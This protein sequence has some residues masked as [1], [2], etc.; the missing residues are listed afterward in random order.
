MNVFWW[1]YY[2]LVWATKERSPLITPDREPLLYAYIKGKADTIGCMVEAIGVVNDHIHLIAS[3][4][5][6]MSIADFVKQIKGSSAH[7]LNHRPNHQGETFAWQRG[8]G[9]LT[10]GS[11]QLPTAIEYVMNQ[12]QHHQE[13]HT[14]DALE[15]IQTTDTKPA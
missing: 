4:P 9:V 14:I 12:K 13:A 5:P 15:Y 1:T 3:I 10:L 11:K 8:Y 2:H 6:S 7:H